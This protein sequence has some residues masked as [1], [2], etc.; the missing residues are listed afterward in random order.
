MIDSLR[1]LIVDIKEQLENSVVEPTN[2][3]SDKEPTR[4]RLPSTQLRNEVGIITGGI[5][6]S[7]R[8]ISQL[9]STEIVDPNE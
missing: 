5:E 8:L 3:I 7:A 1:N 6:C 9:I 2:S 4:N